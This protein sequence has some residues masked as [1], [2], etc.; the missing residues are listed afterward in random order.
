[1]A[2]EIAEKKRI[3]RMITMASLTFSLMIV[4]V[5]FILSVTA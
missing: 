3:A 4:M 5:A 1:M 2:A